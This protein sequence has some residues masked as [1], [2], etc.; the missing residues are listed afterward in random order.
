MTKLCKS[1]LV[2]VDLSKIRQ[3]GDPIIHGSL[4]GYRLLTDKDIQEWREWR[5]SL[6]SL[7]TTNGEIRTP[8]THYVEKLFHNEILI[9]VRVRSSS[10]EPFPAI[11]PR[12]CEVVRVSTGESFYVSKDYLVKIE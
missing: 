1:D 4:V 7:F 10:K 2:Q 3:I 11:V 8:P 12:C 5:E 6:S 9:V